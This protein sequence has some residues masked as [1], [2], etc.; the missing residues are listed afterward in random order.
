M[1]SNARLKS[2]LA[3]LL[4]LIGVFIG[5]ALSAGVAWGHIE[6]TLYTSFNGDRR[7]G[8]E[9]PLLMAP[10]ETGRISATITNLTD[11]DIKPVVTAEIS[12]SPV[13]RQLQQTLILGP[14]ASESMEWAVDSSDVI[15]ERLIL[16]NI[17]QSPYRDNPSMLGSCGII[18]F[19]LFGLTGAVTLWL[20]VTA[21]LAAMITGGYIWINGHRPLDQQSVSLVR[22]NAVLMTITILALLST[23]T[24]LWGL[25]VFFD[26]L[27][28][29][30]M[31]VILTDFVLFSQYST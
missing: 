11:K 25:A 12:G 1:K 7:L 18:L 8:I 26:A 22:V 2:W 21:S 16:V 24:H 15:F 3:V 23:V 19:N 17:R 30:T 29:L 6:A 13:P 20:V 10:Y 28:L 14:G 31:G 9:C 27:I 5:L 4:F